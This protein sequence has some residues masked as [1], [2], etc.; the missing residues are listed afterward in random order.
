MN[1]ITHIPGPL[2]RDRVEIFW[3]LDLE[4]QPGVKERALPTGTAELVI[5]LGTERVGA[6]DQH[7]PD[8]ELSF[9]GAM[10]CGPHSRYFLT[11]SARPETIL[12]VHFKPGGAAAFL[13]VP[14]GE[15][16]NAHVGLD[17]L[18]GSRAVTLRDMLLEA[19]TPAAMFAVLERELLAVARERSH[20]N[21]AVAFALRSFMEVPHAATIA[22]VAG[23]VGYSQRR[24]IELFRDEVGM[25]PKRFCRVRRFQEVVRMIGERRSVDWLDLAVACGYYDQ[26]HF[27][28]DFREFS[29]LNPTAYLAARGERLF[30]IPHGD[31]GQ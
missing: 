6:F 3:L 7:E 25:T 29:G 10:I 22:E 20:G 17:A 27:I 23:N 21:P 31:A 15:L 19:R 9:S 30:H 11:E 1:I 16:F 24:F 26:A 13:G 28:A 4:A 18:W 8:R 14:A 5:G 12:G 2:L